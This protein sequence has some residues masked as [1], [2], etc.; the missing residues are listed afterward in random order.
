[1]PPFDPPSPFSANRHDQAN[2]GDSRAVMSVKGEAKPLSYD[3]KPQ[4]SSEV[5]PPD[6]PAND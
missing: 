5:Y 2:A 1:M 4:N 6:I 3:H